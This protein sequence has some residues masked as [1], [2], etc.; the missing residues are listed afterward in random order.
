VK[1]SVCGWRSESV[2]A[3]WWLR[4]TGVVP[5]LCWRLYQLHMVSYHVNYGVEQ[6]H[7][8]PLSL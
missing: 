4:V 5:V 8:D 2:K 7:C 3:L 1:V 6:T